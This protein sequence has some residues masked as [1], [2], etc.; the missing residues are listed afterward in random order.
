MTDP[1]DNS[2]IPEFLGGR[3]RVGRLIG[4]G[5]MGSV[6]ECLDVPTRVTY[7]VKLLNPE[8]LTAESGVG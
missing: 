5:G 4:R 8:V 2:Q 7:A 3:Y 6:Y 1:A